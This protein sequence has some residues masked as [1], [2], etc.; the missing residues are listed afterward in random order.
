MDS[1]SGHGIHKTVAEKGKL[2]HGNDEE[3]DFINR[4]SPNDGEDKRFDKEAKGS[5]TWNVIPG[6]KS[7]ED[8]FSAYIYIKI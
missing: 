8:L 3:E 6:N 1:N 4:T 2:A 7:S 5:Q